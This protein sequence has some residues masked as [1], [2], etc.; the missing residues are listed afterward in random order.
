MQNNEQTP[1]QGQEPGS[2]GAQ[3]AD[4]LQARIAE[5]EASNAE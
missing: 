5:L 4:A 3:G 1:D 2:P